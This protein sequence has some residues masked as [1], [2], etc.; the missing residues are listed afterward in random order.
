MSSWHI[1]TGEYPP[2]AGGVSDYT[3]LVA[4]SLAL[5]GDRVT[6]WCPPCASVAST[7][8]GVEV[9]RLPDHFGHRSLPVLQA[10]L[11]RSAPDDCLLVQ[12]VP[13]AFGWKAMNVPFCL[14]LSLHRPQPLWV[15]FH[16]VAFPVAPGQRWKHNLLG[17]VTRCMAALLARRAERLFVSIPAWEATLRSLTPSRC[18][19]TWLPVPSNIPLETPAAEVARVRATLMARGATEV[20]GHFGTF[21]EPIAA[22]LAGVLPPLLANRP[23]RVALLVGR[24]GPRF[25]QELE[26]R[27]PALGGRLV[28]TGALPAEQIAPHLAACDVLAQPFPDGVSSRR[29]S[30]MAGLALG[31]P[32]VTHAG[33]LSEPLW[34]DS[35]AVELVQAG[36]VNG[37]AAR[38]EALLAMPSQR[39]QLAQ[40]A[41]RLYQDCFSLDRTITGLRTP[42]CCDACP[43]RT[44]GLAR[45]LRGTRARE[46]VKALA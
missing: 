26:S 34:R 28:A 15:M 17:R 29:T 25:A 30:L 33:P 12:Y 6:V 45:P 22:L 31:L 40:K 9:R 14:W 3:R 23:G 13:H 32:T 2:Q 5:A 36:E 1:L 16:E 21:G 42:L 20:V 46:V 37:F 27:H 19:V 39:A 35:A 18:P 4:R 11:T 24:G 41:R 8:P 44:A 38:V 10:G 43:P 7:D